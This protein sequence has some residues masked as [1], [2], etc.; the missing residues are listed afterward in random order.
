MKNYVSVA[1]NYNSEYETNPDNASYEDFIVY[2]ER[3][4]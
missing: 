3:R 2:Q 1:K 4:I